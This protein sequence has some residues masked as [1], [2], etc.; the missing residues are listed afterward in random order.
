[1]VLR[2]EWVGIDMEVAVVVVVVVVET[3]TTNTA[4]TMI[5]DTGMI[6]K[7]APSW[8]PPELESPSRLMGQ[9]QRHGGTRTSGE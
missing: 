3:T 7:R 8:G 6:S 1:M 5:S 4:G 2:S 9:Q